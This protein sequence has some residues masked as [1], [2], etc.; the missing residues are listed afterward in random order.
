MQLKKTWSLN[1]TIQYFCYLQSKILRFFLMPSFF[2]TYAI[3]TRFCLLFFFFIGELLWFLHKK[4]GV[5]P[6]CLFHGSEFRVLFLV[7]MPTKI[8]EPSILFYLTPNWSEKIWVLPVPKDNSADS[9]FRYTN[10][11]FSKG[12][13][14]RITFTENVKDYEHDSLNHIR[15]LF[16]ILKLFTC[17]CMCGHVSSNFYLFSYKYAHKYTPSHT[18]PRVSVSAWVCE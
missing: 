14:L 12:P 5:I 4:G 1:L 13:Y 15:H 8:L 17:I 7:W 11:T 10:H 3:M 9:T 16:L 2:R 6:S 18:G